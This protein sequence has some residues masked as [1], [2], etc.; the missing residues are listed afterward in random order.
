MSL[1][2]EEIKKKETLNMVEAT[3]KMEFGLPF[4]ECWSTLK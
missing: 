2:V 1:I 3:V 4:M